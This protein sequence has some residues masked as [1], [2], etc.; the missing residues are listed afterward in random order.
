MQR[1][2][3]PRPVGRLPSTGAYGRGL[4]PGRFLHLSPSIVP[5][6]KFLAVDLTVS[7]AYRQ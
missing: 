3:V 7:L 4:S 5:K 1:C 6:R 2:G